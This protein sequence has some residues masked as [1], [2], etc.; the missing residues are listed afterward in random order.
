VERVTAGLAQ[1]VALTKTANRL[2]TAFDGTYQLELL[3]TGVGRT[4]AITSAGKGIF[5]MWDSATWSSNSDAISD[6]D[7]CVVSG[8]V[9]HGK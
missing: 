5:A 8:T 9:R 3:V 2:V 6:D 4:K 1:L 7:L